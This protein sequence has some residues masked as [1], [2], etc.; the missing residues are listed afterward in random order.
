[1]SRLW[2]ALIVLL[3]TVP[4]VTSAQNTGKLA[5]QVIDAETQEPLPG[6]NIVLVG[7]QRGTA[8]DVNGRYVILGIPADEYDVRVSFTGYQQAVRENVEINAGYTREI[9]FELQAGVELE[10]VVVQYEEP[11]IQKDAIGASRSISGTDIENLPVRGVSEVAGLQSG[12]V[13]DEGSS[14]LFIR[15]GRN[16]EVSY[17]VD[18]VKVVGD[19][20]VPQQAIQ[21]QEML[22]GSIPPRYGDA[23]SGVISL[24]T[25]TGTGGEYF[26]TAEAIS[27]ELTDPYGYNLGS[28]SLGGPIAGESISFFVSAEGTSFRDSDPFATSFPTLKDDVYS[29]LREQPQALRLANG[30]YVPLPT[31]LPDS[32]GT[33]NIESIL[34]AQGLIGDDQT[35]ATRTPRSRTLGFTDEQFTTATTKDQPRREINL[36]GNLRIQPSSAHDLRIGGG[37]TT[38]QR[39][40]YNYTRALYSPDRYYNNETETWR[41]YGTWRQHLSNTTFY[42]ISADYT[43]YRRWHYPNGFSRNVEDALFYGDV[44]GVDGDGNETI[45][46]DINAQARRYLQIGDDDAYVPRYTDGSLPLN[47]SIYGLFGPPGTGLGRYIKRETQQFSIQADATTQI[48]LHELNFGIEFERRTKRYFRLD[49]VGSFD[50]ARYYNDGNVEAGSGQAVD[51]YD[52]IPFSVLE[53]RIRSGDWYGY[54]YHGIN[55]VD[56][57]DLDAFVAGDNLSVAPHQPLY[58]AG[59]IGDKIEYEDVIL[60]IGVRAD[61]FDNN[62]EVLRDPYAAVPIVRAGDTGSPPETIADNY[63]A[64]FQGGRAENPVVGYRDLD[65]NFYDTDGEE[66]TMEDIIGQGSPA[67]DDEASFSSIFKDYEAQLTVMPRIGVSFPITNRALFFAS[68][69]V[70][71]Q[72][73]SEQAFIP[74]TAY[75]DIG[76]ERVS[77]PGLKPERTTEYELGFRQRLGERSALQLS[78]FYRTQKN[79]IGVRSLVAGYPATF[80][81]YYNVDFTTTKGATVEFDLR[82]TN[83]VSMNA[84]YTLSFAQGTGSDSETAT[85]IAW[86]GNY[87]PDFIT[88]AAF[89]R[90]HNIN[91]SMDYRL[92]RDEGPQV[93]GRHILENFGVNILGTVR[94]GRPFTQFTTPIRRPIYDDITDDIKGGINGAR[95]PW[96]NRIDLRVDREFALT[97]AAS[98]TGFVWVQNLLDTDNVFGVYRGTGQPNDDG[99]LGTRRGD[100]EVSNQFDPEAYR[101]HYRTYLENPMGPDRADGFVGFEDSFAGTRAYGLPRRVR[102][103]V[104]LNF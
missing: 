46:H 35:L 31:N 42:Q 97:E 88:P 39:D 99:F 1:M 54:D 5:G 68:Y 92:G 4:S 17:Y 14:N 53:S 71:S 11:I 103:G 94:S 91:V 72:R 44:D 21:E 23:M 87:F 104:R 30:D 79:K 48:G 89:D 55:K 20:G 96:T 2:G 24:S 27:S 69:N 86:R 98:V 95:M 51:S 61:W 28:L 90:R 67:E 75:A 63:A 12:V 40:S 73:P 85:T 65:G 19:L 64:Y 49:A 76:V 41:V 6:A 26:G 43:D 84:N 58:Y 82:R 36:H 38:D 80:D 9:D 32:A 74:P 47:G 10:E 45:A 60:N 50:F 34:R 62:T 52:E 22:I 3:L 37:Y 70:T 102:L 57:Q 66:T 77:N 83:N 25:K 101:F 56:D 100:A 78:G 29:S 16:E 8:T 7:T 13:S 33:G 59:Y 93:L 15:G 81:S 18:G